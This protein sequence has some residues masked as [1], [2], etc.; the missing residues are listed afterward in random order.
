L[1]LKTEDL[2]FSA[3]T[4]LLDKTAGL[5][6]VD[7]TVSIETIVVEPEGII[8]NPSEAMASLA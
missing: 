3:R 7:A 6:E 8:A 4:S 2:R 5:V 1:K